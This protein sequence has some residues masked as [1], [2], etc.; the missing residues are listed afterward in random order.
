MSNLYYFRGNVIAEPLINQWY[1]H[2]FLVSPATAAMLITY[3]HLPMLQ[4]YV[5][6]PQSHEQAL[7]FTE[8]VGGPFIGL[9]SR[10][11]EWVEELLKSIQ[12]DCTQQIALAQAIK[13]LAVLLKQEAAG[14]S[15]EPFYQRIPTALKGYVELSYDLMGQ[16]NFRLLESLL[17]NSLYYRVS[18]QS[19]NLSF[20]KEDFRPFSL[21][22]P[23]LKTEGSVTV[24][25]PF[26]HPFYDHLFTT[27]FQPT[28][29]LGIMDL[30][31]QIP[32]RQAGDFDQFFELFTEEPPRSKRVAKKRS[33]QSDQGVRIQYIGHAC[34]LIETDQITIIT[35]PLISY[36]FDHCS[37][38]F[39]YADLPEKI[40]YLLITHN[41]QDHVLIEHLLQLR[42]R[43]DTV[44][45]PRCGSG[46]LQDPSLKLFFQRLGFSKVIDVDD[47]DTISI[48]N[49]HITAV[50]FLGEH[51][52][53]NIRTKT[54]Y[55]IQ[56]NDQRILCIAD[57][58]AL[59]ED[60]YHHVHQFVGDIDTL[61]LSMECD[62]AAPTWLYGALLP[63]PLPRSV[64]LSRKL[65]A[66]DCAAALKMINTF[67]CKTVYLYAMG[68][69]PWLN[70]IMNVQ[71]AENSIPMVEINKLKQV[72]Q[73]KNIA[74]KMLINYEDIIL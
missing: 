19:V 22:T 53:F 34:L 16:P 59:D 58:V 42:C 3:S 9:Q 61:F 15:L 5:D 49:G 65:N 26:A 68:Q 69:E 71:Y 33:T 52:D 28:D 17:Y 11:Q 74:F 6:N 8:M 27:R 43:I 56:L 31:E 7:R 23:R 4:S 55:A 38:R 39:T 10:H 14:K 70:Y 40:D 44:V 25:L 12:I 18:A 67:Q 66:S 20:C 47:L 54:T 46:S 2:P 21:S 37:L 35:D 41:H 64:A 24:K 30:Y 1:A 29:K 48:P 57:S 32:H 73:Q 51:G 45:A 72:C 63:E 13:Q 36:P 62:G 60:L 50:P